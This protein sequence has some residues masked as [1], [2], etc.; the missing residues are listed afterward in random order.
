M[1]RSDTAPPGSVAVIG[2]GNV[3]LGDDGFGPSVV[4]LLRAG[5][6]FPDAV[7]LV[8]AGTPGLHLI[9]SVYGRD[10][11]VLI[12][13]VSGPG[14]PGAIHCYR[15][16]ELERLPILPRV[17]PHDPAVLEALAMAE[18]AGRAP[19]SVLVVGAVPASLEM[20]APLS[21]PVRAACALAAEVVVAEL[22]RLGVAPRRRRTP[23]A[24][25]GWWLREAMEIA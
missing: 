19:Q 3:L 20:G 15:R 7:E 4:A 9:A 23:A 12:D 25:E 13:A 17:S 2:L 5:W 11:L 21:T 6:Q 8:D 24:P 16:E 10:A 22:T 18:L 1:S 14:A